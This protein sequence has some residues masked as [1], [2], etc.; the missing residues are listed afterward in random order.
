MGPAAQVDMTFFPA[1]LEQTEL[2][3]LRA[4]AYYADRP[5]IADIS[6][7]AAALM[8]I[9]GPMLWAALILMWLWAELHL[10]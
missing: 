10:T 1:D 9:V 2:A 6:Q 3:A 5:L 4:E 7:V 8:E